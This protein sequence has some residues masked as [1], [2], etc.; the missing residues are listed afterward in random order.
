MYEYRMK[1][2]MHGSLGPHCP[3]GPRGVI[4]I[5]K[6][7]TAD[8]DFCLI[9]R[10]Y[11]FEEIKQLTF[12]FKYDGSK[13]DYYTA[14]DE[15]TGKIDPGSSEAGYALSY[16][17]L[18]ETFTLELKPMLTD[19]FPVERAVEYEIAVKI[20]DDDIIIERQPAVWPVA[21]LYSEINGGPRT[22]EVAGYCSQSIFCSADLTCCR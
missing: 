12:M 14:F 18:T 6:G 17:E 9:N 11:K 21:T 10:T 16:N 22:P 2:E 13:I 3:H 4:K 15:D 7:S 5:D 8:F 19:R 20:N 1:A